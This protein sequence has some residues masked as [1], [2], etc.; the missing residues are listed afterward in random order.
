MKLAGR[1]AYAGRDAVVA[2]VLEILG[3]DDGRRAQP[4]QLR[5]ERGA[6]RPHVLV[7]VRKG[8]TPARS[9]AEGFVGGSMG[10]EAVIL[11]GVESAEAAEALDST[12]HGAGRVMSRSRAAGRRSRGV[13][14]A[15]TVTA[16][17]LRGSHASTPRADLPHPLGRARQEGLGRGADPG[18]GLVDWP[19]VRARSRRQGIFLVGGGADEAPEVYKRLPEVLAA[20]GGSV[21]V[22]HQL[23]RSASRWRAWRSTTRTRTERLAAPLAPAE[24]RS[25]TS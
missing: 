1:Y 14:P 17:R 4:P 23:R 15:R 24:A 18:A 3:A 5:L 13:A 16:P 11:E 20:H 25:V 6:L 21:R 8:C 12:V 22:K 19:A 7:V 2:K 9:G 10:D